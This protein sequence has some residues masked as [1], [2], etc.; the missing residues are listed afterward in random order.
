MVNIVIFLL[1]GSCQ[2]TQP[3]AGLGLPHT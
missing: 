3:P 2:V 1:P